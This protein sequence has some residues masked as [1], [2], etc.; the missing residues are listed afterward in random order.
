MRIVFWVAVAAV[1]LSAS[2]S[3]ATC[4]VHFFPAKRL[5]SVGEDFDAVHKLDQDLADYQRAAGRP[6]NWLVPARQLELV[7]KAG[8]A[9]PDAGATILHDTPLSRSE[10]LAPGPRI[11]PA[12][13]CHIEIMVPQLLME[14]GGLSSRSLRAFGV[15]RSYAAGTLKS[16]YSGFAAAQLPGFRL[17]VPADADAA[18]D[19]VE[20][21]YRDA[22]Q[23]LVIQSQF[24][25]K[26]Q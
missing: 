14:R 5:Q 23:R 18:T 24:H 3:A 26:P 10:A 12:P 15:V 9:V 16:T 22:I 21:A 13:P 6:L 8:L 7:G 25:A 11:A 20:R 4:D 17:K 19:L 1:G 2:A